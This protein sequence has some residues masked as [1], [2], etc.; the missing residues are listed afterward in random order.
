MYCFLII[1]KEVKKSGSPVA[2]LLVKCED[3]SRV[4]ISIGKI[5]ISSFIY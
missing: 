4:P 2:S 3:V 5:K 1:D